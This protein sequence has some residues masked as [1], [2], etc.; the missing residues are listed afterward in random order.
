M[1]HAAERL[2]R[3][4]CA[5]PAGRPRE[6][7]QDQLET[8]LFFLSSTGDIRYRAIDLYTLRREARWILSEE[9]NACCSLHRRALCEADNVRLQEVH[10][11]EGPRQGGV[12]LLLDAGRPDCEARRAVRRSV[13]L[14]DLFHHRLRQHWRGRKRE[15]ERESEHGRVSFERHRAPSLRGPRWGGA[16]TRVMLY[17]LGSRRC[18]DDKSWT[19]GT[20][21]LA[22]ALQVTICGDIR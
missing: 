13:A 3:D 17:R 11:V 12:L 2:G 18:C 19:S 10:L 16:H 15:R 22:F 1:Q 6:G 14:S 8:L 5:E 7:H 4:A 9:I 21:I 20:E